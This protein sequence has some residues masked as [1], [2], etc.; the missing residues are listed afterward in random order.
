MRGAMTMAALALAA[1]SASA[2]TP[3]AWAELQRRVERGCI[4]ASG[5]VQ[6]RVSN[7]IVFDD[8]SG[9]V[10]LLVTGRL[11]QRQAKGASTAK[12]CLYDRGT[13]RVAMEE[14]RGWGERP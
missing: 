13:K 14:A 10:A 6:P 5:L 11:P 3:A 12:L 4:Q 1:G 2:S 7:M 9:A 8:R